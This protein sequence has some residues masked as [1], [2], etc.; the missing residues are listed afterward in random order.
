MKRFLKRIGQ[1][2]AEK[3]SRRRFVSKMGKVIA[4]LAALTTGQ[5]VWNKDIA[6]ADVTT[7]LLR[8]CEGTLCPDPHTHVCPDNTVPLYTWSCLDSKNNHNYTCNDCF[9]LIETTPYKIYH[10]T[11]TFALCVPASQ[12]K[13][14][15]ITTSTSC[16]SSKAD[17]IV[18]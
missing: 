7:P 12:T 9:Q 11:C 5:V 16:Q 18:K 15:A 4:T 3:S 8:C 17:I 14:S 2:L 10:Y 13:Q 1:N 6:Y